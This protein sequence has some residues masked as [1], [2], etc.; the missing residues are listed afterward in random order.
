MKVR[1]ANSRKKNEH[2]ESVEISDSEESQRLDPDYVCSEES[3]SGTSPQSDTSNASSPLSKECEGLL[4]ELIE[5]I[6]EDKISEGSFLDSEQ[7]WHQT[8][9]D[10]KDKYSSRPHLQK[11][12]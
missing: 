2:L 8:V 4:F 7:D 6:G 1:C 10:F 11:Y 3:D 9:K 12:A 5:V